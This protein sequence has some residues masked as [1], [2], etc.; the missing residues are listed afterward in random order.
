MTTFTKLRT[1]VNKKYRNTYEYVYTLYPPRSS[2][3]FFHA[4]RFYQVVSSR[5]LSP[6]RFIFFL[7]FLQTVFYQDC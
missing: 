1:I 2:L 6:P 4:D 3:F 7:S 5:T